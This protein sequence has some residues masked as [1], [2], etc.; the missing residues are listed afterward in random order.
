VPPRTRAAKKDS[1][2]GDAQGAIGDAKGMRGKAREHVLVR[3]R[4]ILSE[5]RGVVSS[6]PRAR[7]T[8]SKKKGRAAKKGAGPF[9]L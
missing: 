2:G 7:R 6:I 9:V 1:L 8:T 5:R 4:A 3:T